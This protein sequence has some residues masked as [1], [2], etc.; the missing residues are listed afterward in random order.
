M[1]KRILIIVESPSFDLHNRYSAVSAVINSFA[2]LLQD[3][4]YDIY[5]NDIK[6]INSSKQENSTV[7]SVPSY[8]RLFPKRSREVVKDILL[9]KRIKELKNRVMKNSKPD[10][11]ISW[12]SYGSS[13]SVDLKNHWN[14]PLVSIFD[15]P[16]NEE[17]EHLFGFKPFFHKKI[18]FN[19]GRLLKN[20]DSIIVY[21][22]A[23]KEYII[24]RHNVNADFY[25]KAFTD[26]K[27][28]TF[29]EYNRKDD[30][31]SFAYIGSFFNWHKIDDL[32]SAFGE[33]RHA[34]Y[35]AELTLIGDGVEFNRIKE[36]VSSLPYG[37]S[38]RLTGRLDAGDLER[39]MEKINVGIIS[40]SLWFQAPVKLFQYSAAQLPVIYKK[41]PTIDE[42]SSEEPGFF[43]FST[44][45][46]LIEKMI[47]CLTHKNQLKSFGKMAQEKAKSDF[48]K[49]SYL[50]FF[51]KIFEA[52]QIL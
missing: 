35:N 23:V 10:L 24:S 18:D 39:E 46:E 43:S 48:S 14:V 49:E 30:P 17:Y 45:K 36:L 22:H 13:F 44:Q 47:Y 21:S 37:S 26:F 6:L 15:N 12:V 20:S 50:D 4:G 8:Y 19:E 51:T 32:I 42:L 9:F 31:L 1:G 41:T 29:K 27:R 38:I 3:N 5:I 2:Y 25:F 7:S 40:N 28:M 16:L 34:G 11:I 33:V 52:N